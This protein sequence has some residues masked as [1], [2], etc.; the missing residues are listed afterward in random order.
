MNY[1]NYY[2]NKKKIKSQSKNNDDNHSK[3]IDYILLLR[4]IMHNKGFYFHNNF[5]IEWVYYLL[6]YIKPSSNYEYNDYNNYRY[7]ICKYNINHNLFDISYNKN[8]Y[9]NIE[10]DNNYCIEIDIKNKNNIENIEMLIFNINIFKKYFL[11]KTILSFIFT[12]P[13]I[14]IFF[15]KTN[16][17]DY[18]TFNN[19][20]EKIWVFTKTIEMDD[21]IY[22][23]NN[24][25][26]LYYEIFKKIVLRILRS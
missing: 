24:K 22:S 20:I 26:K 9:K 14:N 3:M 17:W 5:Y 8:I 21:Y 12:F 13:T 19:Y 6:P 2:I 10:F 18:D 25:K 16:N 23:N 15:I 4:L 7:I 1:F 11:K